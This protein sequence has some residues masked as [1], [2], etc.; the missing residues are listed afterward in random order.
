MN[1]NEKTNLKKIEKK[2]YSALFNDGTI[3]ILIGLMLLGFGLSILLEDLGFGISEEL[4]LYTVIP[5]FVVYL[6][7]VFFVTNPRKGIIKLSEEK[8]RSK[9]KFGL[10]QMIWLILALI[11]GI[12]FSI[13]PINNGIWN[14]VSVSLFWIMGSI[15]LFSILAYT[16]KVDRYYIYGLLIAIP[17]PFRVFT[18]TIFFDISSSMFLV[19]AL[20]ILF[21]GIIILTRFIKN[22]PKAGK[23]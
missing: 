2:I 14:D 23:L 12:Y 10:I 20:I 15:F 5:S 11:V 19:V 9:I 3:D 13:Q 22:T 4:M 7:I 21:W 1:M 18:K 17:F 6:V 8:Q 16:V